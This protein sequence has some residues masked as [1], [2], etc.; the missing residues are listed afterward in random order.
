MSRDEILQAALAL[1]PED[2]IVLSAELLASLEPVED[3]VEAAW[4]EEVERRADRLDRGD[5]ELVPGDE[6]LR[7]LDRGFSR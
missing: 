5:A 6:V 2:R 1:G 7:Q 3:G 4:D